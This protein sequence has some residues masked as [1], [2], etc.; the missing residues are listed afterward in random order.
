MR[1]RQ[2][3]TL[4][5]LLVVMAIIALLLGLLLPALAKARQTARQVKCG[6]QLNQIF[7]GNLIWSTD[8]QQDALCLPGLVNRAPNRAGNNIP[9]Q[10]KEDLAR[11]SHANLH[12]ALI[13]GE[14]YGANILVS[15][16]ESSGN[17]LVN[18]IYDIAAYN[19]G[20]DVYWDE[21]NLTKFKCDLDN[22]CHTSYGAMLLN[23]TRKNRKWSNALDSRHV[24]FANRGIEDSSY[25]TQD[26][27][28]SKTLLIHGPSKQW[29][30]NLLFG[31]GHAELAQNFTPQSIAQIRISPDADDTEPDSLFALEGD[32]DGPLDGA[33]GQGAD[34]FICMID[35]T[36]DESSSSSSI[37]PLAWED[38]ISWD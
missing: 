12:A 38:N 34:V 28:A 13:T 16:S 1:K 8:N 27:A 36:G 26:Y 33:T 31:D 21:E 11:N 10:G 3:F 24:L 5:E 37:T 2:G 20:D 14:Y 17:V 9:G 23:G 32:Q 25:A 30:G 22:V 15:P 18:S 4:I 29:Q 19:P 35:D 7:K 6:T